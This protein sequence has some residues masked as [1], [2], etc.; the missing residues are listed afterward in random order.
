MERETR[1]PHVRIEVRGSEP[2]RSLIEPEAKRKVL[3]PAEQVVFRERRRKKRERVLLEIESG[4]EAQA[5]EVTR[6][7][8]QIHLAG[9]RGFD[10]QHDHDTR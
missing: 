3:A 2:Q 8:Q 9:T 1:S 6:H 5:P 10:W 7:D 4:V